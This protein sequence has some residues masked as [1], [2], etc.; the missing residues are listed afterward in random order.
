MFTLEDVTKLLVENFENVSIYKGGRHFHARCPICG[1]SKKSSRKKRFH[2]EYLQDENVTWHCFN[3]DES[4]SFYDI[5]AFVHGITSEQAYAKFNKYNK[6]LAERLNKKKFSGVKNILIDKKKKDFTYILDDCIS[7]E[8]SVEGYIKETY[9]KILSDFMEERK[10]NRNVYIAYKGRFK[11]RI[12]IPVM[13]DGK[14]VY[15]QGRSVIE[16]LEPKY[17]NPSVYKGNIVLNRDIFD[18][19]KYVIVTEGLLDA[20]SVGQQGTSILGKELTVEFI[21][22]IQKHTEIGTV[23]ALDNDTDGKE[24]T[25]KFI[26]ENTKFIKSNRDKKILFFK[27]PKKFKNVKDFNELVSNEYINSNNVYNFVINNSYNYMKY[28][29]ML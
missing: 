18:R 21:K 19:E 3:C 23:V 16:G 17:L 11:G 10:I 8:D 7:V 15:F 28:R 12:I 13:E 25:V 9:H 26:K 1:D 4:G 5:Y 29:L 24:K 22:E 20:D 2:L 14:I 27:M 6:N